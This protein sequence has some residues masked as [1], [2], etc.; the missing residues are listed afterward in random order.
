MKR[1]LFFAAS[2]IALFASCQK[3]VV[4]YQTD[5]QEIALFAVNKTVTK[6]P[7]QGTVFLTDDNMRVSAYLSKADDNESNIGEYFSNILYQGNN[8]SPNE[9]WVG[10]QYWPLFNSTINFLAITEIGGSVDNTDV[11]FGSTAYAE[12]SL[13]NNN[14]YSQNDLMFAVGQGV[15]NGNGTY[16]AVGMQ[17]KH[18]LSWIN[19]AFKSN[20]ADVITV[21][22]VELTAKYNGVLA[23]S[24]NE[25]NSAVPLT[26]NAVS[27]NWLTANLDENRVQKV[28]K[29]DYTGEQGDVVLPASISTDP[30]AAYGGGLL[31]VPGNFDSRQFVINYKVKMKDSEGN[32]ADKT[33]KYTYPVNNEWG[34]GKKY[35]YNI[36]ITLDEIEVNPSVTD[37]ASEDA[38]DVPLK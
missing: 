17:F 5:P 37:W 31:V 11:A 14:A 34:M 26:E 36:N 22:S 20:I 32:P 24:F 7:V 35:T 13:S 10:G 4:N 23:V 1:F 15:T 25:Y 33:F 12:A 8:A 19:F 2:A 29:V 18:A 3:T 6:A 27:A 28:P 38:L 30:F 9:Y 21:N 16:S